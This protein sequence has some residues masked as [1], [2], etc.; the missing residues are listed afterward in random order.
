M[1]LLVKR[2]AQDLNPRLTDKLSGQFKDFF[3]SLPFALIFS[4][5]WSFVCVN[6]LGLE[7]NWGQNILLH[8][9]LL[10]GSYVL[11]LIP[12]IS[13]ILFLALAGIGTAA[14][15]WSSP[16]LEGVKGTLTQVFLAG[17]NAILWTFEATQTQAVKPEHYHVYVAVIACILALIFI[18]KR[19]LPLALSIFLLL[20]FFGANGEVASFPGYVLALLACLA[21]LIFVFVR[22]GKLQYKKQF[23]P[24]LPLIMGSAVLILTFLL[25]SILPQDF[26][27]NK[28]L[29]DRI[30]QM[31]KRMQAPEIVNYYEFSLRDAGYYPM[32][33][34]LGGPLQLQHE[35]YMQVTGPPAPLRLRGAMAD[36]Y[37][38][39][40][41]LGQEMDPNYIFDN[42]SSHG[43]QAE[44]FAYPSVQGS[45][46][47]IFDQLYYQAA[48]R[49]KPLRFPV[50][51]IF[52]GGRPQQIEEEGNPEQIYYYNQGGQIYASHEINLPYTVQGWLPRELSTEA[53]FSLLNQGLKNGKLSLSLQDQSKHYQDLVQAY[54]PEL[55]TILYG[56]EGRNQDQ[57]FAAFQKLVKHLQENYAYSLDVAYP[58]PNEDFLANFLRDKE[59]YCTYFA[60]ALA[61]FGRELGLET[62][63]VEGFLVPGVDPHTYL[64]TA[65][66]GYEREVL[67]DAAHAWVEV[68]FNKLGW[69]PF[70]ATPADILQGFTN[71]QGEDSDEAKESETTKPSESESPTPPPTE[72]STPAPE[73]T[74]SPSQPTPPPPVD[75]ASPMS[76]MLK[77]L[78][79][80]LAVVF[81]LA[82]VIF[83]LM[84]RAKT[85]W[86]R[87]QDP[88]YLLQ[89]LEAR[90]QVDLLQQ[91]WEDIKHMYESAGYSWQINQTLQ[92][93]FAKLDQDLA[94]PGLSN[95]PVYLIMEQSF[96]G[97]EN[98]SGDDLLQIFAYYQA[99][100]LELK[101]RMKKSQWFFK[102][103]LW[104]P[105]SARY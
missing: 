104:P 13:L 60:T 76:P 44:V 23:S 52:N 98:L 80:V 100:E 54:D 103:Y 71:Q 68:K 75:Q 6:N 28:D 81:I 58:V 9:A 99:L 10:L 69:Y 53:K 39:T 15:I 49:I 50:Q 20:P 72:A 42:L 61:L 55:Y 25:Q 1:K 93:K 33:Q 41:W 97:E 79:R 82:L 56:Q 84:R 78:L 45:A 96:F 64:G 86:T 51:V 74:A 43:N 91:V 88:Q 62:R 73:P 19:P 38:G 21:A 63:Y 102:R 34:N 27:Q 22:E 65:E 48:I 70:D 4:L 77:I 14:F 92:Q 32:N 67:S 36:D 29:A 30:R 87:R 105:S 40:A 89:Q 95:Y 35:L 2:T 47:E 7:F 18:I 94:V 8:L 101:T 83:L 90:D 11:T 12:L 66:G 26:F 57:V 5:A 46:K 16:F 59:G 24:N 85:Y 3:W 31:Q 37:T 17:K